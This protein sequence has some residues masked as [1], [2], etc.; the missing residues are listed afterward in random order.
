MADSGA[1]KTHEATPHRREEARAQG[2]IPK[3]Q[4]LSSAVLLVGALLVFY[5]WGG[6]IINFAGGLMR[7]QLGAAPLMQ[8]DS[9]TMVVLWYDTFTGLAK[10]LLPLMLGLFLLAIAVQVGQVGIMFLPEKLQPKFKHINP[11]EGA[12]R[13]FSLSNVVRF[14]FGLFKLSIIASV[15]IFSLWSVWPQ[16]LALGDTTAGEM[17]AYLVSLIFWT[18]V[19]I[20]GA[21]FILA[22]AEYAFQRWKFEQ[23]LMMTTQEVRDEMKNLQGDPQVISRRRAAQRQLVMNR[24]G[25]AVPDADVIVTNP[26]ELAIAIKYD[27]NTMPE[28]VVVAKGAG[29]IAARIRRLGLENGIPIVERKELARALYKEVEVN[30]PVPHQRFAAVAEVLRYVYDLKGLPIPGMGDQSR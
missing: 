29:V 13:L 22:T 27:Y 4:D 17:S 1:D 18:C 19:K 8:V 7:K 16:I 24:V 23:D 2:Q 12:K 11:L 14:G 10:A 21:L 20:A 25:S 9:E 15:A 26:T 28:P 30:Q 3:S 5:W 6:E